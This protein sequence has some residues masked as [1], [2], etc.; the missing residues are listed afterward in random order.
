MHTVLRIF[1]KLGMNFTCAEFYILSNFEATRLKVKVTA[2]IAKI[3]KLHFTSKMHMFHAFG[4]SF[5]NLVC[6]LTTCDELYIFYDPI[7]GQGHQIKGQC[8]KGH[9]CHRGTVLR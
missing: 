3:T 2:V 1:L 6:M 7:R 4:V 5:S 9:G 8:Y